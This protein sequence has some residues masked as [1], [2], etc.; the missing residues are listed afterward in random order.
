MSTARPR[1]V[2]FF[3]FA[4]D[5]EERGAYLRN[6]PEEARRVAQVLKSAA[7]SCEVVLLQNVTADQVFDAFQ[8]YR[9]RVALF[10]YAGH[11]NGFQ[12]LLESAEGRA[13]AVGASGLA[14]FLGQQRGLRLVFLNGCSTQPQVQALLEA[15]V[16]AVVATARAID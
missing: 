15:N 16:A 9:D 11:A 4:N 8:E 6:L 5:R 3:A 13:H 7:G 2:L 14:A 10:H 1:P 12:L